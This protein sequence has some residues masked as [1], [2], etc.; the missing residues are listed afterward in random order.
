MFVEKDSMFTVSLSYEVGLKCFHCKNSN[1]TIQYEV[2]V[3]CELGAW[4]SLMCPNVC[5]VALASV[6]KYDIYSYYPGGGNQ[7]VV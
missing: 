7:P 2:S 1:E 3:M 4:S 6:I 5:L